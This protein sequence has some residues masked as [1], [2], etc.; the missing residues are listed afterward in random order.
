MIV[1]HANK[2]VFVAVP[3]NASTAIHDGFE[4]SLGRRIPHG[5][6]REFHAT[7]TELS[8]EIGACW[9]EYLKIGF[10]RDPY[11]RFVSAYWDFR[12]G[13]PRV[14]SIN[15]SFENFCHSFIGSRWEDL[16]HFR[17]QVE[18]LGDDKGNILVDFLGRYENL[19]NDWNAL[20][21]HLPFRVKRLRQLRFQTRMPYQ[22]E[23]RNAKVK[24]RMERIFRLIRWRMWPPKRLPLD[25]MYQSSF[26]R[27]L[28]REYYARDFECFGYPATR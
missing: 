20:E 9:M 15:L 5:P 7:A 8:D 22:D 16:R 13:R 23:W 24:R 2:F 4:R 28:V 19:E 6:E 18:F 26:A 1:D 21:E 27:Q 12:F 11:E 25:L 10:V 14:R 3:K 17:P